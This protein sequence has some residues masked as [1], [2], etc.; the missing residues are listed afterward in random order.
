MA[1][2]QKNIKN[3]FSKSIVEDSKVFHKRFEMIEKIDELLG[4]GNESAKGKDSK[5]FNRTKINFPK[6]MD[7]IKTR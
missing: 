6:I 1:K 3:K 7:Q 4:G 5:G 2:K